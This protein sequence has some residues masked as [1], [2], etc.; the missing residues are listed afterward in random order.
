M[1]ECK[2]KGKYKDLDVVPIANGQIFCIQCGKE[3]LYIYE[4]DYVFSW[5]R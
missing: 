3:A 4:L 2:C 5:K 1:N